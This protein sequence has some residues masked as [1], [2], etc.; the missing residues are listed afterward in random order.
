METLL[1]NMRYLCDETHML[2]GISVAYGTPHE[3][4]RCLCGRAQEITL[5]ENGTFI[6]A[7]R[8]LHA[9]SIYDLASLSKLFTSVM[10]MILVQQGQLSLDETVGSIDSRF[11]HLQHVTV[12]DVLSFRVSLQTPGRLDDAPDRQEALRRLFDVHTAPLPRIRL[13]SDI[14]AMVVKYIIEQKTGLAFSDALARYVFSPAGLTETFS[15]VPGPLK[16]RCVCYNYEHRIAGDTYTLRTDTTLASPHDP[17]A[18]MLSQGGRDLCGHAGLFSTQADMIRFAQALLSGELLRPELLMQIGQNRTGIS[19]G[20]GTHR[21]YLGYLCFTKH[22]NQY[23]SEV[24]AWMSE[25]SIGLSGFTGNH[26]SLDPIK[27]R[28]VLFLG[29]RCHGRVSHIVPKPGASLAD[30]G[31]PENGVGSVAWPDG[32]LVPSS[33][34]YVHFK[35]EYLHAPIADRMRRIGWL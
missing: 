13:Y 12:A 30:Y 23:L 29:N 34:R 9:N 32:R 18:A 10:A 20:D 14:N 26:L 21:Q 19:Y 22:P 2:T 33:V 15:V 5:S 24:P 4:E 8:V 16:D 28:F 35:D 7:V 17:K 31:L 3:S 27:K 6:P 11:T 1:S 25:V